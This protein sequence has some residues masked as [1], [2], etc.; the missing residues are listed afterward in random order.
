MPLVLASKSAIRR[1]MLEAAGVDHE[2]VP[3]GIDEGSVKAC[4]PNP[5]PLALKL[6]N[7]KAAAV[8]A[9]GR[10][11][12]QASIN[13]DHRIAADHPIVQARPGSRAFAALLGEANAAD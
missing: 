12:E 3:A 6:A 4:T 2:A 8:S 9:V 5:E 1:A 10:L 7:A 13:A 11:V